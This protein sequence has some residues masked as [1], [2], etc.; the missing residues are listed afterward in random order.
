MLKNTK[1]N[2]KHKGFVFVWFS[3]KSTC[4]EVKKTKQKY[5]DYYMYISSSSNMVIIHLGTLN[6]TDALLFYE[7]K[8]HPHI[9]N[10]WLLIPST[11]LRTECPI[12]AIALNSDWMHSTPRRLNWKWKGAQYLNMFLAR[13][14]RVNSCVLWPDCTNLSSDSWVASPFSSFCD[15]SVWDQTQ[16]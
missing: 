3:L 2:L 8:P 13:H 15:V 10:H 5:K 4:L 16:D 14:R 11:F 7:T 6:I 1:A 9:H 12:K